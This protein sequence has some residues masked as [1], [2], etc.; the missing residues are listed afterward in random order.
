MQP[1]ACSSSST[2][3][4]AVCWPV[5]LLLLLLLIVL[6]R[7]H[8][9]LSLSLSLLSPRPQHS[10]P[11]T[12]TNH[13]HTSPSCRAPATQALLLSHNLPEW[14]LISSKIINLGIGHRRRMSER[15]NERTNE[16]SLRRRR[17]FVDYNLQFSHVHS[18]ETINRSISH[19]SCIQKLISNTHTGSQEAERRTGND[20]QIKHTLAHM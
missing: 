19:N 18:Y 12:T 11:R 2:A 9:S 6:T 7:L 20:T 13:L 17:E 14:D 4:A 5:L 16:R 8:L 1:A 15:A 3:T 10:T